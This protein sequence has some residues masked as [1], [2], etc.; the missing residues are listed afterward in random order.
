VTVVL[1]VDACRT[2]WVGVA[3]CPSD[4][5]D[6]CVGPTIEDLV[7]WGAAR[8][9]LGLVAVDMPIGLPDASR[10]LADVLARGKLGPRRSSVFMTPVRAALDEDTHAWASTVNRE[11]AG[12]GISTQAFNLRPKLREVETVAFAR[13]Y[14]IVEVHPE[15][16]FARIAGR[17]LTA[18]KK[19]AEGQRM[20]RDLLSTVGIGV[21]ASAPGAAVDD[22]LDAA[23]AA[24]SG[25][26]V[27][28]GDAYSLPDPP[29][30]FSDGWPCAIWV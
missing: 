17:P 18:S 11:R 1:G 3:L 20:R 22:V 12:E 27:V 4:H 15:V 26:R 2:G 6:V 9:P 30:V 10:R 5:A 13:A 19:T 28:L 21:D 16:S 24:W 7:A 25:R 23:V 8:G 29:E 14:R